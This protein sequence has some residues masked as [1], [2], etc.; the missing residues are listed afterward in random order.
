MDSFTESD[1][2]CDSGSE[3]FGCLEMAGYQINGQRAGYLDR[4]ALGD[5]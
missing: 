2:Q 1:V 4:D 5:R 3:M